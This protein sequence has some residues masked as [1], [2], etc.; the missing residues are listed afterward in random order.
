MRSAPA[1]SSRGNGWGEFV[2]VIP[3]RERFA[4][5]PGIHD[6]CW[7]YGYRACAK[8]TRIPE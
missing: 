1:Q 4:S 8:R 6:H 7:E 5:E 3:G 2:P